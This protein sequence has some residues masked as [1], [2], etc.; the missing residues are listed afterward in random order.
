MADT[1]ATSPIQP[2]VEEVVGK[3]E[4][5]EP[6]ETTETESSADKPD[7]TQIEAK[8]AGEEKEKEQ[9]EAVVEPAGN[10][11]VDDGQVDD[12]AVVKETGSELVPEVR[13]PD[14]DDTEGDEDESKS[15]AF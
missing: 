7:E 5:K 10:E 3:I 2:A 6:V 14:G 15:E 13:A 4:S 11:K 8:E 12:S 1:P 9:V